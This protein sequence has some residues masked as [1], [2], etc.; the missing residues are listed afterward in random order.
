MRAAICILNWN[1]Q[2][3]LQRFLPS[4][5]EFSH[6]SSIYL[7][8]NN[9][10]DESVEFVRKQFS[11]VQIIQNSKN[12]G[13]TCG[14]NTGLKQVKEELLCLLN[15]DVKVTKNWI[16]PIINLFQKNDHIAVIQPKILSQKNREYFEYAG[17]AGGRI[18]FFGYP[19][20]RG[21]ILQRLEKDE[22]QY[23]DE[24]PIFWASG[25]CFFIRSN[26]FWEFGGFDNDFFAHMEEIDLCWRINNAN[27]KVYYCGKST[28]YH[29]GAETLKKK[30]SQKTFLNFRNN[31]CMMLKNLP[32]YRWIYILFLRM[33]LDAILGVLFLFSGKLSHVFAIINAYLSFYK[34]FISMYKKR[35]PGIKKYYQTFSI[36]YCK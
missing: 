33:M 32:K 36:F 8:D 13:F 12:L 18:D 30:S 21:R 10:K 15:S 9:S 4:V 20:C 6:G 22:G 5:I 7:I 24:V 34:L 31:L 26:V 29:T 14:Y 3:L 23:N 16:H 27:K 19:Y 17:A 28:V 2:D 11:L 35:R 25:A 1:G